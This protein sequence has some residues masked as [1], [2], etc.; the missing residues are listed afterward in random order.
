MY[1]NNN[2]YGGQNPYSNNQSNEYSQQL[3]NQRRLHDERKKQEYK[4]FCEQSIDMIVADFK[5]AKK[6]GVQANINEANKSA[7]VRYF[8]RYWDTQFM[9]SA[10][11]IL[12]LTAIL[13][14]YTALAAVGILAVFIMKYSYSQSNFLRYF[15]NDHD[16]NTSEMKEIEQIIF[17]YKLDLKKVFIIALGLSAVSF[18][19]SLNSFNILINPTEHVKLFGFLSKLGSFQPSNELF[20][21]VNMASIFVL[22]LLKTIEKWKK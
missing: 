4:Y 5:N 9:A 19:S 8:K 16:I 11:I 22:M 14:F 6:N 20:A 15:L 7:V 13:S 10:M 2:N 1:E 3:Q 17:G 12:L 21:Y 18:L